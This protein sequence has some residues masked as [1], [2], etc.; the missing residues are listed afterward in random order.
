MK[1]RFIA[2]LLLA[3]LLVGSAKAEILGD[4][5]RSRIYFRVGVS[6]IDLSYQDNGYRLE[7]LI[8]NIHAR[9]R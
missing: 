6:K 4:T 2:T 1:L 7:S 9:Q 5:L 3:V 8:R